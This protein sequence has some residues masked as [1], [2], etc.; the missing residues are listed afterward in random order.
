MPKLPN[1]EPRNR[2]TTK[3]KRGAADNRIQTA[4]LALETALPPTQRELAEKAPALRNVM[5]PAPNT[6]TGIVR[7]MMRKREVLRLVGVAHTTV[8]RWERARTFPQ[9]V[10]LGP[11]SVAWYEDEIIQWLNSRVRQGGKRLPAWQS[12]PRRPEPEPAP[13]SPKRRR[14][15]PEMPAPSPKRR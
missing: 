10:Q 15:E 5:D 14:S 12:G 9:R 6:G 1:S 3:T 11:L 13:P 7:R 8:W 2:K 4:S